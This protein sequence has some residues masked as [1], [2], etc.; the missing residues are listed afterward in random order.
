MHIQEKRKKV[1][2]SCSCLPDV[3]TPRLPVDANA[4][5]EWQAGKQRRSVA[6]TVILLDTVSVT[7]RGFGAYWT[8]GAGHTQCILASSC[9]RR[10]PRYVND[11]LLRHGIHA[12]RP[13]TEATDVPRVGRPS[14]AASASASPSRRHSA[15]ASGEPGRRSCRPNAASHASSR[16]SAS[17]TYVAA[18]RPPSFPD[19][20]RVGVGTHVKVEMGVGVRVCGRRGKWETHRGDGR[21]RAGNE[22]RA[23]MGA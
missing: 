9:Q 15:A 11:T 16:T 5:S 12:P 17:A 7:F 21:R 4:W 23:T 6:I 20:G 8:K 22:S 2:I 1:S 14:R 10:R 18:R 19:F 3:F 13:P